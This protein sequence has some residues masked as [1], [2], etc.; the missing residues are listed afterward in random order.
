MNPDEA[1][2]SNPCFQS[3]EMS[4]VITITHKRSRVPL[5]IQKLLML[6]NGISVWKAYLATYPS[7]WPTGA[8]ATCHVGQ[9]I[10]LF[11]CIQM[12]SVAF[13]PFVKLER[14]N[15]IH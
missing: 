5:V 14:F 10:L 1:S 7:G 6:H 2:I 11:F 12:T 8:F 4:I 9:T 15:F 13:E 3:K